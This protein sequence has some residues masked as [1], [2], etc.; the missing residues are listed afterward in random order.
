M[1]DVFLARQQ[2]AGGRQVAVKFL[3]DVDSDTPFPQIAHH[4]GEAAFLGRVKHPHIV[5]LYDGGSIEGRGYLVMEYIDGSNLREFLTGGKPVSLKQVYTIIQSTA[6]ALDHLHHSGIVHRDLKPENILLDKNGRVKLTD[7]G[8]AASLAELENAAQ[9]NQALGTADY[10]SPEQRHRLNIDARTDQYSL[11]VIAYELL[12]GERPLGVFRP[13]AEIN[14]KLSPSVDAV[15]LRGLEKDPEDR[16]P[17]VIQFADALEQALLNTNTDLRQKRFAIGL[18]GTLLVSTCLLFV[19]QQG[20]FQQ[21]DFSQETQNSTETAPLT[22]TSPNREVTQPALN[23]PRVETNTL[24]MGLSLIP[25]GDFLMG[26]TQEEFD[27]LLNYHNKPT[28]KE[29]WIEHL[30]SETPQHTVRINHPFY[31]GITEVTVGQFRQFITQSDFQTDAEKLDYRLGWGITGGKWV[32]KPEFN[33]SNLG[34]FELSDM[35][36]V[37]NV[38]YNDAVAFCTWLSKKEKRTYRLPTEAEWEYASRAGA[39]ESWH[40]GDDV[41]RLSSHAWTGS[42]SQYQPHPVA[43][44]T[45]NPWGLHDIYGNASEWCL[46]W[47]DAT[48]YSSAR[49][50]TGPTTGKHRVARGGSH[51]LWWARSRSAY[52]GWN[53]PDYF[54]YDLGFRVALPLP[55]QK[56]P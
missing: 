52:R 9:S 45:P 51:T 49:S 4:D 14:H 44:K 5:T 29:E 20:V 19:F 11:A 55:P 30:Q 10:S 46:D 8:I 48:N 7:L 50:P 15:I 43:Q 33:W 24:G 18:G 3:K 36:P 12:T 6:Q 16:Y 25:A 17:T 35:H 41:T 26:S 28:S 56:A 32:P 53:S 34:E 23:L 47:F 54:K 40:F 38:S 39:S 27:K 13:P 42:N 1:G 31:L 21:G 22:S 2:A 37:V